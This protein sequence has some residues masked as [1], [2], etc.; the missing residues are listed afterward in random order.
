M[1]A[2]TPH[3]KTEYKYLKQIG[4]TNLIWSSGTNTESYGLSFIY[5][6]KQYDIRVCDLIYKTVTIYGEHYCSMSTN[7][8]KPYQFKRWLRTADKFIR[9][10]EESSQKFKDEQNARNE[11]S[12]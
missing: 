12:S 6:G 11:T 7:W 4:A 1:F 9:R 2:I 3:I 8:F 10:S 5:K